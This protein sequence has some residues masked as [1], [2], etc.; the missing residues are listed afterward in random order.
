ML[1]I[2]LTG[3]IASGKSTVAKLF[4]ALGIPVIDTDEIAREVVA[5][6]SALLPQL[7][8]RF[9]DGIL[10]REGALDRAALRAIVFADPAA[11]AELDALTHPA[12]LERMRARSATAGGPYQILAIPLLVEKGAAREVDR[13]LVI[14]SD[15]AAQIR[16]LQARDGATLEQARAI[17]AAQAPRATRLAIADDVIVND[18]DLHR[19]RDQVGHLHARYVAVSRQAGS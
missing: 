8:A 1:R 6:G 14:D 16:R 15:E 19:L 10:N 9:G 4:A 5:P 12:I 7:I 2:G 11:R 17:L 13:V 18:G 3:G